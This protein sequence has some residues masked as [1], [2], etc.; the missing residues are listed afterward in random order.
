M[1]TIHKFKLELIQIQEVVS[2]PM[3]FLSVQYQNNDI[4]VWAVVDTDIEES[5]TTFKIVGTGRPFPDRNSWHYVGT[6]QQDTFVWHIFSK[7]NRR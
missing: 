2:P 4:T 1:I 3:E 7:R 5:K 6:V